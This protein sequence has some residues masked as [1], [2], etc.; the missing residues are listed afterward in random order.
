M[1]VSESRGNGGMSVECRETVILFIHRN[2]HYYHH[3]S[4]Y[5]RFLSPRIVNDN[6]LQRGAASVFL[7]MEYQ[8]Q[9]QSAR[10][11]STGNESR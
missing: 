3:Y 6:L 7:L 10:V 4:H 2:R 8:Y 5:N 1:P 9:Y 11:P